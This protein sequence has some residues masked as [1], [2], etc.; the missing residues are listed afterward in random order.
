MESEDT[1][2]IKDEPLKFF[3]EKFRTQVLSFSET[4]ETGRGSSWEEGHG[5]QK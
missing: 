4:E 5:E 1:G 2:K 3:H